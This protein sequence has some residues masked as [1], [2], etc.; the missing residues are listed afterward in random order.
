MRSRRGDDSGSSAIELLMV[1]PI[2]VGCIL[3]VAGAGRYVDARAEVTSASFE[4][5]RAASLQRDTA[6][7]AAA[8]RQAAVRTLENKGQSCAR[9]DVLVDVLVDVS[10]YQPGGQVRATVV[11]T[12]DLS[13]VLIAGF[14]GTKSFRHTAVV[15]IEEHR[16]G[17]TR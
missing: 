13:D 14:P 17:G 6:V 9:L 12:A 16:A 5:A 3:A 15:P 7:S 2:L 4:A 8:G 10:S 11:C 1:A